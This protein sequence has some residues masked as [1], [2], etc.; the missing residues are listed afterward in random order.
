[1]SQIN[2]NSDFLSKNKKKIVT[3]Q[4]FFKKIDS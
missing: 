2:K 4:N 1:M 3:L